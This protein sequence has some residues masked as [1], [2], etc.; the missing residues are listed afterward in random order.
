VWLL[1]G[2]TRLVSYESKTNLDW[3]PVG[4]RLAKTLHE[5]ACFTDEVGIHDSPGVL[6][7]T[8]ATSPRAGWAEAARSF[9]A[10]GLLDETSATRFDDEELECRMTPLFPEG[11]SLRLH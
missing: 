10:E 7:I 5:E 1:D 6:T 2:H 8:S 9:L 4:D 11:I 3:A